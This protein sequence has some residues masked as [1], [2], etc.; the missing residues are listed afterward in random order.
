MQV[1]NSFMVENFKCRKFKT[2]FEGAKIY[3]PQFRGTFNLSVC[4]FLH[5]CGN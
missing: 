4:G 3:T 2:I 1:M 5:F